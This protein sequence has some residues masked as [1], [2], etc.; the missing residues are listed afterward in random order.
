MERNPAA[1]DPSCHSLI[2]HTSEHAEPRLGVRTCAETVYNAVQPPPV[3]VQQE[4]C[5]RAIH[6]HI[7]R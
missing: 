7:F 3:L 6:E 5:S 4:Q 2:S 1:A